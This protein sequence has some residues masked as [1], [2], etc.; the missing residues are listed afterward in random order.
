M[1]NIKILKWQKKKKKSPFVSFFLI[2]YKSQWFKNITNFLVS[3]TFFFFFF[4]QKQQ[5]ILIVVCFFLKAL[6]SR[7]VLWFV[8]VVCSFVCLLL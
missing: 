4:L 8:S 3:K 5:N 6:D 2:L 7:F 1:S